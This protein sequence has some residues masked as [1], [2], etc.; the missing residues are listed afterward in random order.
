MKL[1]IYAYA[2]SVTCTTYLP[3]SLTVNA[4]NFS[5][6]QITTILKNMRASREFTYIPLP[7]SEPF[8]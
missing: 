8:L 2:F 5:G 1:N 3:Q 6:T 4:L 7:T